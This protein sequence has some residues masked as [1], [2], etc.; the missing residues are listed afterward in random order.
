MIR[1]VSVY[2]GR[3]SKQSLRWITLRVSGALS[4]CTGVKSL[5]VSTINIY[6]WIGRDNLGDGE[7]LLRG[8][9]L[10]HVFIGFV[11][12]AFKSAFVFYE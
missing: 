6:M 3:L 1:Q 5:Q 10:D 9:Y 7:P 12:R 2:F 8:D 4:I 11:L